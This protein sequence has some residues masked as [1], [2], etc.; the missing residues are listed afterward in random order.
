MNAARLPAALAA[1]LRAGLAA[2]VR[3]S[4][5]PRA[6]ALDA[7]RAAILSL[8]ADIQALEARAGALRRAAEGLSGELRLWSS[9]FDA[10]MT[11]HHAWLRH[12]R[13]REVFARYHLPAC[14]QCAVRFEE[15]VGEAAAAYGLDREGLLSELNALLD[16]G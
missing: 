4:L 11:V 12:P 8:N 15:T 13:A 7:S 5:A 1:R 10:D 3:A 14:D 6:E 16:G 2:K 9:P